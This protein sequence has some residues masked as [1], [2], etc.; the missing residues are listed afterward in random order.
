MAESKSKIIA[1]LTVTPIRQEV[2]DLYDLYAEAQG[3]I[4]DANSNTFSATLALHLS[5][6]TWERMEMEFTINETQTGKDK[7]GKDV[8]IVVPVTVS[9]KKFNAYRTAKS[10]I[11]A[12]RAAGVA[13]KPDATSHE[14]RKLTA[15]KKDSSKGAKTPNAAG[16]PNADGTAT[17]NPD[18][19]PMHLRFATNADMLRGAFALL[20]KDADAREAYADLMIVLV[21]KVKAE[22]A[23]VADEA[24]REVLAR[25]VG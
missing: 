6:V 10:I 3:V 1:A 22:R 9:C 14:L 17:V 8:S 25:K 23:A 11:N 2:R 12:A 4:N 20:Q 21:A 13:I 16:A 15:A 19:T 7:D 5:G 18:G 24:R